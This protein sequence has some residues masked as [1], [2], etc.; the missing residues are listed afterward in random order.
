[1]QHA[2]NQIHHDFLVELVEP[3]ASP[4]QGITLICVAELEYWP[5][6]HVGERCSL[7]IAQWNEQGDQ[8]ILLSD[9]KS[10]G[11]PGCPV[12]LHVDSAEAGTDG[13]RGRIAWH[14]ISWEFLA[15]GVKNERC[16]W[17]SMSHQCS[18]WSVG[19]RAA[20]RCEQQPLVGRQLIELIGIQLP[21]QSGQLGI[22]FHT[23]LFV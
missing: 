21:D 19:W 20:I 23:H 4:E 5:I 9:M 17:P 12:H 7:N 18:V 3:L 1:M 16:L 22:E 14:R 8:P 13:G 6:S 2:A 11:Q 15:G 10:E